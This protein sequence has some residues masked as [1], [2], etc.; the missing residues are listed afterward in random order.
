MLLENEK[1]SKAFQA[2]LRSLAR[3]AQGKMGGEAQCT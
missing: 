3:L 1:E 2:K